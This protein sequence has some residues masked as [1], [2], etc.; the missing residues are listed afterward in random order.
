MPTQA[1]RLEHLYHVVS[2]YFG[3]Q[4]WWP[5]ESPFEVVVGAI[6]TQNTNWKNVEKAITNLKDA[7]LL[8]LPAL[9]E[10]PQALL[11]EYIRP[12]GYYNV[13]AAR[14]RNLLTLIEEQHDG[15]LEALLA[16]PLE[17]LR[18]Q[19]LG[20]KGIG[21]ETADSIA[22]YA[23]GKPVFVVDTYT[24]RILLRHNLIDEDT[25]YHALQELFMD[26]LPADVDLYGEFHA[27]LVRTGNQFCRKTNPHCESC[28]LN[29]V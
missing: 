10:L 18:R 17:E 29:G 13:K 9:L 3:P 26:N 14:L 28:P 7:G 8:S 25:D 23:A 19:L 4:D 5:G 20:V 6:L 16:L 27:L 11:A 15:S 12:A 1:E 24:H 22:L 2:E 21:P